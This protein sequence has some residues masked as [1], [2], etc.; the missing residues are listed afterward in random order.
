MEDSAIIQLYWDRD[1]RA[2]SATAERYGGY[3][4]AIALNILGSR[5]DAEECVSDTFLRAWN[6]IPP[7]RPAVLSAFLGKITRN[8]S[9]NRY[10]RNTAAKR[11]GGEITLA[12]DELAEC[13]PG[14]TPPDRELEH[15]DLVRA[16]DEFL[17]RLRPVE[18]AMFVC[19]YWYFDGIGDISA[20]FA[21]SENS[22]SVS[23]HRTR[24][25]LHDFLTKRGFFE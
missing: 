24:L 3:C 8:L 13:V 21:K 18:R 25:K 10:R 5:E 2:V 7:H 20:R 16:I 17:S 19:R 9:L 6:S 22:V 11:G 23:L 14:G 15:R 4:T 1:E 12:L